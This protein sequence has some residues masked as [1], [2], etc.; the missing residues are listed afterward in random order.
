VICSAD[1][2]KDAEIIQ[3]NFLKKRNETPEVSDDDETI[4]FQT[5]TQKKKIPLTSEKVGRQYVKW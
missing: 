4:G 2:L 3:K 5:P 1:R